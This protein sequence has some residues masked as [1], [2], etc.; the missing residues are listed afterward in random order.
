[1]KKTKRNLELFNISFL[2]V[3]SCGFGAIVLLLL[4]SKTNVSDQLFTDLDKIISNFSIQKENVESLEE[5]IKRIENNLLLLKN[6]KEF[7]EDRIKLNKE[8]FSVEEKEKINLSKIKENLLT[9]ERNLKLALTNTQQVNK[10][11]KE[12][13]GIPVDSEYITFVIDT[14]GSMKYIWSRV[15]RQVEEIIKIHPKVK[16]FRVVN[17]LGYS[18]GATDNY[19]RD[20]PTYR[21]GTIEQL[22][23]WNEQSTSNPFEGI[24]NSLKKIQRGQKTSIYVFGDDFS[25]YGYSKGRIQEAMKEIKSLNTDISGKRKARI[26]A[27]GFISTHPQQIASAAQKFSSLMKP[28]TEENGGAFV[29]LP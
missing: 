2:D 12:V 20:T 9:S 23:L 1:M 24:K 16:G 7:L 18:L 25:D 19:V 29:A 22:K 10:E 4:V 27:I 5:E 8:L 6:E 3:I 17:D 11:D 15:L 28:L 14:S 21:K 13:A 26:H